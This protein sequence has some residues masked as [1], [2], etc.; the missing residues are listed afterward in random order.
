MNVTAGYGYGQPC[1]LHPSNLM[2]TDVKDMRILSGREGLT[3]EAIQRLLTSCRIAVIRR[4]LIGQR[5][6]IVGMAT[7][8][9]LDLLSGRAGVIADVFISGGIKNVEE[10]LRVHAALLDCLLI[11][12][13]ATKKWRVAI[14]AH[15]LDGT[16]GAMYREAGFTE[17]AEGTL[18]IRTLP[19]LVETA[20]PRE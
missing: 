5:G 10:R 3:L 11:E 1:L 6:R 2:D 4:S 18:L 19:G 15:G 7:L 12:A 17:A 9:H 20:P 14:V 8:A 16:A 13:D